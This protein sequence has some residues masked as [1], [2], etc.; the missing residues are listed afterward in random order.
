MRKRLTRS[1]DYIDEF[2]RIHQR[3]AGYMI[4]SI[5]EI[6]LMKDRILK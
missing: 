1:K 2:L 5:K 4:L 6:D 3:D